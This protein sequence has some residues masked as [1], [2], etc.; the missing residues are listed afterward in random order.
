MGIDM[1]N[2]KTEIEFEDARLS[3]AET[4]DEEAAVKEFLAKKGK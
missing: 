2:L 3:H 4:D 1:T